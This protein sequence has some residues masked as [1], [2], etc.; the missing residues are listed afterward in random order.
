METLE[1]SNFGSELSEMKGAFV[2]SLTRNNKKI[3]TDRAIAIAEDA[4]LLFKRKVEDLSTTLKRLKRERDS[5][6]DLSPT[7]ADSLV[8]ASDFDAEGFV[9]KDLEVGLSIRN[10]EI[11][12]EIAT[13]R[14]NELFT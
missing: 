1:N 9:K 5:L 12:L 13:K 11:L 14:Y 4:E 8:L 3:R 6:L 2:Q 10:T 7:T